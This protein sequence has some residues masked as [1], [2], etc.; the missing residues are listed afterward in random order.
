MNTDLMT[1]DEA[2][3]EKAMTTSGAICGRFQL[4]AITA[5]DMSMFERAGVSKDIEIIDGEI[6]RKVSFGD[7]YK[8]HAAAYI[9]SHDPKKI[10]RELF[11]VREFSGIVDDWVRK[12]DITRD[13]FVKLA[14]VILEMN[15]LWYV[16]STES[17][18]DDSGN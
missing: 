2:V 4:R 8:V 5:A 16:C 14:N 17:N 18:G 9:L 7:H 3:R 12:V 6:R 15:Q 11:D 1:D 10:S 13:E